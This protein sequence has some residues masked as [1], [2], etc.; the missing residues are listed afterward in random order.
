MSDGERGTFG[1]RHRTP[2]TTGCASCWRRS[3]ASSWTAASAPSCPACAR[4]TTACGA[5]A[6]CSTTRAVLDVHRRLRRERVRRHHHRHLGPA[7]GSAGERAA[8]VG[9]LRPAG[10][11]DGRRPPRPGAGPRSGRRRARR[12][13]LL[14]QRR[15]RR[16]RGPGDD[17]PPGPRLRRRGARP[18]PRGDA[19]ARAPVALRHRRAAAGHRTARVALLPPLPPRPVRRLRR[20]LGRPGGRRL[21]PRRA[22][23][24]GDGHR[25]PAGQLHPARSRRRDGLLPARLHRPAARGLSEPRL[26]DQRGLAVRRGRRRRGVR[27]DGVALAW[28]GCAD[29][30]RLLRR[31]A[32]PHRRRARRA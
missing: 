28:G 6:R 10:A 5:S 32:R 26:P 30:R 16:Q 11:L 12:R 1:D 29:H 4:P 23:L 14:A 15:R 2:A 22:A 18:R 27:G 24:R 13:R 31:H 17:P 25:R 8:A 3:A 21:R 9:Q 19:V 7:V 20:A